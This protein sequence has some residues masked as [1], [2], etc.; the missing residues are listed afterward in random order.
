MPSSMSEA[1][2]QAIQR[3]LAAQDKMSDEAKKKA[4]EEA[5]KRLG[6]AKSSG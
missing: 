2:T 4:A 5:Q 6:Y 1:M 3:R